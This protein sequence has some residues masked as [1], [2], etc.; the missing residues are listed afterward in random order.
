MWPRPALFSSSEVTFYRVFTMVFKKTSEKAATLHHLNT[1]PTLCA[2]SK[3]C[4]K[5][6]STSALVLALTEHSPAH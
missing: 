3:G 6:H 1:I 4:N 2:C 5:A